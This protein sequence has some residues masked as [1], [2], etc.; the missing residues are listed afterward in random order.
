MALGWPVHDGNWFCR[1]SLVNKEKNC[2]LQ[3]CVA[4]INHHSGAS[5]YLNVEVA[6]VDLTQMEVMPA[7]IYL[8]IKAV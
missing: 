6:Y 1:F 7:N 5:M 8:P 3:L 2:G 4:L